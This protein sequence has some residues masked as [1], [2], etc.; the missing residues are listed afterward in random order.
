MLDNT[1][2]LTFYLVHQCKPAKWFCSGEDTNFDFCCPF[3]PSASVLIVFYV[4]CHEFKH[5]L[6]LNEFLT[7]KNSRKLNKYSRKCT[8]KKTKRILQKWIHRIVAC[9]ASLFLLAVM[10][11]WSVLRRCIYEY[12][13]L[14]KA[15]KI[16]TG[17]AIKDAVYFQYFNNVKLILD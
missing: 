12:L 11:V 10:R 6:F 9:A 1:S 15:I 5:L 3:M 7:L 14:W 2:E 16:I 8:C 13:V 4:A 17:W